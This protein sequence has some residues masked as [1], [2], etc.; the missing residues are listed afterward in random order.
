M[1]KRGNRV[2]PVHV[3][4]VM[5]AIIVAIVIYSI[6]NGMQDGLDGEDDTVV[7]SSS[8]TYLAPEGP[9]EAVGMERTPEKESQVRR[10]NEYMIHFT[11]MR[12]IE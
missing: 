2:E 11:G 9:V 12:T 4:I 1:G 7:Y 10:L 6:R 8:P 3:M 5:L